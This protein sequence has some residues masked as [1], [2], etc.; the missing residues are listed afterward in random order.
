VLEKQRL[1]D[2]PKHADLTGFH[3]DNLAKVEAFMKTPVITRIK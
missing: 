3:K 1:T 2:P